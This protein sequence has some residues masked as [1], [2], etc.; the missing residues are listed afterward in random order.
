MS[1]LF[2]QA[3]EQF[4]GKIKI[5]FKN[6]PLNKH[7]FARTAALAALAAAEQGRFWIFHDQLFQHFNGSKQ[8][9]NA[10]IDNIATKSELDLVRFRKDM[11]SSAILQQ[12]NRDLNIAEEIGV[13]STPTIF[14]NGRLLKRRPLN[15]LI[16][17]EL[18]K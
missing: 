11:F 15:E 1:A 17:E 12:L 8:L 14:V 4:P 18:E 7:K 13:D 3:L 6:Y 9:T 16:E 10:D 5:V 2:E